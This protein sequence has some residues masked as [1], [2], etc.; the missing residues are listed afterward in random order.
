M[1]FDSCYES[2]PRQTLHVRCSVHVTVGWGIMALCGSCGIFGC[3][4]SDFIPQPRFLTHSF[5]Q[6]R[7]AGDKQVGTTDKVVSLNCLV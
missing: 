6:G 2:R 7:L 1:Q 3:L 4:A 5:E